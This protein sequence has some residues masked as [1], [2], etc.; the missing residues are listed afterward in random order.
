MDF[1][2]LNFTG[3][4]CK[5]WPA[6]GQSKLA[7]LLFTFEL[8][9]RLDADGLVVTAVVAHPGWAGTDLQCN[10]WSARAVGFSVAMR[11]E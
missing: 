6:C 9:R 8:Q 10:L 2:D 11:P 3:R 5:P 4:S 7:N 1:E